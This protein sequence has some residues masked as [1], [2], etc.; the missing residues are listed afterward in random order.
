MR[1]PP[2]HIQDSILHLT[3]RLVV[4][5]PRSC[6]VSAALNENV[7]D[8]AVLIN[9]TPEPMFPATDRDHNLVQMPF[10]ATRRSPK[11]NA[12]RIFP[13]EFLRPAANSFVA[14]IDAPSG[15]HFFNHPKAQWEPKIE[16]DGV[17]DHL[18]RKTMTTIK[19]ITKE[20]HDRLIDGKSS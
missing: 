12:A 1:L 9:G 3:F 5:P 14:H 10:I 2:P 17:S 18:G 15:E 16:P 7:E 20:G 19:R 6:S 4:K 13:T 8:E 11:A